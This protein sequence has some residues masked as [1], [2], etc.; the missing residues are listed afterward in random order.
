[1]KVQYQRGITLIE[2]LLV[3]GIVATAATG[4]FAVGQRFLV[5]SYLDT[6]TDQLVSGLRVAQQNARSG[7]QNTTWGVTT[8]ANSIVVF[9]GSSYAAR[10]TDF[11]TTYTLPAS[12][13]L[14]TG[15][16]VFAKPSGAPIGTTSFSVSNG[17]TNDEVSIN[18]QGVIDVN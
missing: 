6:A 4:V 3:V 8:T 15:E 14:T 18:A 12:V 5:G 2:I 11:D 16:V 9:A 13:S 1:M 7:K 10:N 17:Q